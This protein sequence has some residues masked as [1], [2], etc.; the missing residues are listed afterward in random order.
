ML[1]A[2]IL[3]CSAAVTP[4]L[5]ECTRKN[6]T[7]EMRVPAEFANPALCLMHGQAYLVGTSLGRD[8]GSND[9]VKI[10]CVRTETAAASRQR[11]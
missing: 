3:I 8:L 5:E 7:V 4:D 1:T 6:A 2:L 10:I 11:R 9:W